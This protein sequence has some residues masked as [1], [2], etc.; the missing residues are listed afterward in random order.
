LETLG[1][2]NKLIE[3]AKELISDTTNSINARLALQYLDK[4]T[5]YSNSSKITILKCQAMIV[6]KEYEKA[7]SVLR[8]VTHD[9]VIIT[10][11]RRRERS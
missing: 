9:S 5:T 3:K 7:A 2:L 1:T 4:A 11:L 10:I 6:L 8:Y